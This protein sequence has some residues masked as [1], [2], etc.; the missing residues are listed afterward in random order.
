MV[1]KST[2]DVNINP[3]DPNEL[4]NDNYKARPIT[5][6][7]TPPPDLVVTN[8]HAPADGVGGDDYTVQLD[9]PEPGHQPDRGRDAVR[10]GLPLGQARPS[11]PPG[12]NQWFLGTVE[13]DGVV[14]AGGSYN[15]QPTFALSPEIAGKYVIVGHQHRRLTAAI[16]SA[17]LGRPVH[18][19]QH[20]LRPDPGDAAAAGRPPGD[21]DRHPGAQLLR[22]ADDRHWTVTNVGADGLVRHPLLGRQRLFLA[23]PDPRH[24]A[25]PLGRRLRPQQ[26]PAAG[27]GGQLHQSATFTLPRHRRDRGQPADL[28]RLRHHRSRTAS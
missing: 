22:R 6:L 11:T 21:V 1:L 25:R 13:H 4:N 10:P 20:H 17:H 9:R 15:A 12:A 18:R 7:L 27:R 26:R 23:Y 16:L 2:L 14:P 5:V 28:L 24:H 3:D 8:G 19:Q